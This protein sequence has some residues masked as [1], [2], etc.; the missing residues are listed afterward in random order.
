MASKRRLRRKQCAT[1]VR[2][3]SRKEARQ[4]VLRPSL[5]IYKCP[6]CTGYH[7]GHKPMRRESRG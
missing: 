1:K 6:F 3:S 5:Q 7:A 2:Y 4:A